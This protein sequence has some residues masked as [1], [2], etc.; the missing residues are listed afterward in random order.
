MT[1]WRAKRSN[2][3]YGVR[4]P[5][6]FSIENSYYLLTHP[7]DVI[8]VLDLT[9]GLE[10]VNDGEMGGG[11]AV[12]HGATLRYQPAVG[13]MGLRELPEEPGLT[14][15]ELADGRHDLTMATAGAF[16]G[17]AQGV[18]FGLP[19]HKDAAIRDA[20]QSPQKLTWAGLANPTWDTAP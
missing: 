19:L 11:F 2:L 9:V 15:A 14:H 12:G 7:P 5:Y 3:C 10:Q 18:Q 1:S 16:Q 20:P 17:L 6:A 4:Q 13:A 8:A